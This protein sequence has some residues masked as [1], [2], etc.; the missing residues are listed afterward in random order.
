MF[1]VVIFGAPGSGK[2]TQ[3]ERITGEYGL[4]HIS[5]GEVLRD[6]ISRGTELGVIADS[7][8]SKGQLIPDDLRHGDRGHSAVRLVRQTLIR[9]G[10]SGDGHGNH[11]IAGT[12]LRR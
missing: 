3:S 8:I 12:L 7:Y 4:H 10:E 9:L 11:I 1:N 6:H 5:T 2:G